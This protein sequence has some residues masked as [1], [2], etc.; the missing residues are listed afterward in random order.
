MRTST[1]DGLHTVRESKDASTP[2]EGEE[3]FNACVMAARV[4]ALQKQGIRALLLKQG[5]PG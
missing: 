2:V 1:E 5:L 4:A 3:V